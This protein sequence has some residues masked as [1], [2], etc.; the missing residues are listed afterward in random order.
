MKKINF[1]EPLINFVEFKKII[2]KIFKN[3][4]ISEGV[5]SLTFEKKLKNLINVKHCLITNSGSSALV[6][7]LKALNIKQN[8]EVIVPNITFQAT[9][10]AVNLIGGKVVLCDI[11]K[12]T[13]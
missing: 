6:L 9:A 1:S 2:T 10:N 3:N 11:N 12:K 5:V 13:Y 4:Y 7:A 8:D